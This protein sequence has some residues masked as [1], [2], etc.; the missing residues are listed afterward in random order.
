MKRSTAKQHL[1]DVKWLLSEL[2]AA[3]KDTVKGLMKPIL[4]EVSGVKKEKSL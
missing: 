3:V 4:P 1:Q 2:I